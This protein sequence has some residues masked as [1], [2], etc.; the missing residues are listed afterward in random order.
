MLA[1]CPFCF[2]YL[3]LARA[4]SSGFS[5]FPRLANALRFLATA[6]RVF[7]A[8]SLLSKWSRRFCILG[9]AFVS[10]W[11]CWAGSSGR[12]SKSVVLGAKSV[13]LDR[14]PAS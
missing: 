1:G 10:G 9:I 2:L 13:S 14:A 6:I 5:R 8:L 3:A 4:T 12:I 7:L 11:C